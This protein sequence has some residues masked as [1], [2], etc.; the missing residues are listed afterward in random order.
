VTFSCWYYLLLLKWQKNCDALNYVLFGYCMNKLWIFEVSI[1]A[2][3]KMWIGSSKTMIQHDLQYLYI[4]GL[5]Q[6]DFSTTSLLYAYSRNG[7]VLVLGILKYVCGT[8][9]FEGYVKSPIESVGSIGRATFNPFG[10][11]PILH[12]LIWH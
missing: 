10:A 5:L 2:S 7:E 12:N 8:I 11:P 4:S 3:P 6:Y 1:I 9:L